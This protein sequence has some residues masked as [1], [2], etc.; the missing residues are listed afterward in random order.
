HDP[1]RDGGVDGVRLPRRRV[2]LR[3]ILALLVLATTL[4]LGLFAARLIW[5]S[6]SQQQ[7]QVD[8][9][10]IQQ[11]RTVSEAIDDEV[12]R[13]FAAL[14][15]LAGLDEIEDPDMARFTGL[16]ARMIPHHPAWEAVRLV[17]PALRVI[18]DTHTVAG[19]RPAPVNDWA[20][21]VFETGQPAVATLRQDRLTGEWVIPIGIPI[22]ARNTAAVT[23]ALGVRLYARAFQSLLDRTRLPAGSVVTLLDGNRMIIAR[24]LHPE[25]YVGQAPT[26]DFIEHSRSGA[27]GSWRSVL[28]EGTPAYA[29]WARSPVTGWTVGVGLPSQAIDGPI[30]R[31]FLMLIALGV[32][33]LGAGI[34]LAGYLS[35][36]VVRT[37]RAAAAAA[38]SLARGEA[39]ASFRSRI[40]E[41]DDLSTALRAAAGTLQ[42]RLRERDEAQREVDRNRAMLFEQEQTARRAAEAL[43]RAKDEFVATVSHELRT[44]LNAIY[45]WVALLQGGHL[46][47]AREAHA[48]SVIER[49]T[50]A[51]AQ[52]IDDLLDMSRIVRG[53]FRLEMRSMPLSD[54]LRAAV[55]SVRPTAA[56]RQI[57]LTVEAASDAVAT[58]DPARLQQILW[59]LLSNSLKFTP[60]GGQVDVRIA[61]EGQEAVVRVADNGEGI[62]P[63]F[64]PFVFDRF[65][66]ETADTTRT[67]SG[68]GIGLALVRYL[69]ELHGGSV[70]AQSPGKGRGS[71]F[72]LRLPLAGPGSGQGAADSRLEA[73]AA[74]VADHLTSDQSPV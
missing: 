68:L 65:R 14:H 20:R 32:V 34:V 54:A 43:S 55:E 46:D 44:P 7:V 3:T 72:T 74:D 22:R 38:Q 51:Q 36:G 17:D 16:A 59:N 1:V 8:A 67:H 15:V 35:R 66:Q 64:L 63:E 30:R 4:P 73:P 23:Y 40:A 37:H 26:A 21:A 57:S 2:H 31:S 48:L 11:A 52:L 19:E 9:Q 61:I 10:N 49:N 42:A 47:P 5:T 25:R 39:I 28:L 58:A 69:T 18:A 62:D 70:H 29:A 45:G 60:R 12:G 27:E 13:A 33:I 50:R 6:W 24:T 53:T 71:I 41:A 56:A